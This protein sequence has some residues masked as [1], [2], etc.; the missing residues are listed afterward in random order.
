MTL[1]C[2]AYGGPEEGPSA[3]ALAVSLTPGFLQ[4]LRARQ[5]LVQR[6]LG[7]DGAAPL[8]SVLFHEPGPVW[9]P[10]TEELEDVLQ[11]AEAQGW[12]LTARDLSAAPHISTDCEFLQVWPERCQFRCC[13][14][15]TGFDI[16]SAVLY[17]DDLFA[18]AAQQLPAAPGRHAA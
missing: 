1:V 5:R 8:D 7:T 13:L 12:T 6:L 9:F 2:K 11:A 17:F 3:D 15:N 10:W 14:R 16:E 4:E 18:A